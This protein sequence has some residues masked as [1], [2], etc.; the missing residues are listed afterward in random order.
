MKHIDTA[1]QIWSLKIEQ[2]D[3]QKQS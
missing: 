2:H 1:K 3:K